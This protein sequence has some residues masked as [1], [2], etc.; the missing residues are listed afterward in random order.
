MTR[1][2]GALIAGG[3]SSRFGSDKAHAL[4]HG[5]PLIEHAADALRP[6][7]DAVIVC[8]R[9]H[10]AMIAVAD[11]PAADMGPL[12]GINAALHHAAAHGYGAVLSAGCDTPVLPPA[13]LERLRRSTRPAYVAQL[14]VIGCWPSALAADLDAFLAQDRKHA[15]RAWGDVI[16]AE[17]IDWPAL[18]NINEPADMRRLSAEK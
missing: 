9:T 13:L 7:V 6:F 5:K 1:R 11:R 8:G 2:L 12:G 14:P 17:P 4:W 16:D 10:G 18:E 15:I 3:R